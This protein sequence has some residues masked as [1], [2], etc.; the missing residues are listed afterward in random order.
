MPEVKCSVSNCTYWGQGNQCRAD[1]IM[2]EVDKHSDARFR[3]EFAGEE[4]DSEHKDVA[5]SGS[6]TCCHTFKPKKGS[7]L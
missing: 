6:S 7:S 5:P 2:I 3:S 4:F 1:L